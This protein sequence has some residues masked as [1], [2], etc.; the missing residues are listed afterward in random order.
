MDKRIQKTREAL[1]Q[2]LLRLIQQKPYEAIQIIDITNEANTARVTFYRHY[3]TKEELLLDIMDRIYEEMRSHFSQNQIENVLDLRQE[4]PNLRL[5]RFVDDNTDVIRILLTGPKAAIVQQ[6]LRHYI[7]YQVTQNF[8]QSPRLADLPLGLIANHVAS[9]TIGNLIWWVI[10]NK[11]YSAEYIAR[12]THSMSITGIFA[13]V[14]RL[15]EVTFPEPNFWQ[16]S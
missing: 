12:L 3:S 10:E 15:S 11:P 4:P 8:M 7:V 6:R 16:Q 13:I 5:F 2:A 9:C 1:Q 14:G